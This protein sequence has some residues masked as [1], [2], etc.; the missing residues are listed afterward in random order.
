MI[1]GMR[2]ETQFAHKQFETVIISKNQKSEKSNMPIDSSYQQ[3]GTYLE[4]STDSMRFDGT[5]S[6]NIAAIKNL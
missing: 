5:T 1:K 4:K 3:S 2:N 6:V